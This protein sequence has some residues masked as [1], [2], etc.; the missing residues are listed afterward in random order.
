MTDLDTAPGGQKRGNEQG[1]LFGN[2]T[3]KLGNDAG[4]HTQFQTDCINMTA[5]G[6]ASRG[7]KNLVLFLI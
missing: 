4:G 6:A 7:Q 1:I 5:P 2:G 3:C